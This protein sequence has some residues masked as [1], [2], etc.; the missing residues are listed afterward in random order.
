M[1]RRLAD[2]R[3]F[4]LKFFSEQGWM[5]SVN[6]CRRWMCE[7]KFSSRASFRVV[8]QKFHYAVLVNILSFDATFLHIFVRHHIRCC[9]I[10]NIIVSNPDFFDIN[11]IRF[12]L[13]HSNFASFWSWKLI[14]SDFFVQ[15]LKRSKMHSFLKILKIG[16]HPY[17]YPK[18]S[19]NKYN[20]KYMNLVR[21]RDI[22]EHSQ[23]T[24]FTFRHF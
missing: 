12:C 6:R 1:C 3:S 5:F 2:V 4:V 11:I 15:M 8:F 14:F 18:P 19:K 21:V 24:W 13:Q 16:T 17:G 10:N 23:I 7:S 22:R 20:Y 9:V